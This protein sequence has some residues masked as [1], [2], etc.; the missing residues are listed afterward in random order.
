MQGV[1]QLNRSE[2]RKWLWRRLALYFQESEN[3]DPRWTLL[4]EM[5]EESDRRFSHAE[6]QR[7][8]LAHEDVLRALDRKWM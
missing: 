2:M 3:W 6:T 7:L 5:E 1:A 8:I 4:R